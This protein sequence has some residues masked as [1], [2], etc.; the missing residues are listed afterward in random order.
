MKVFKKTRIRM[1]TPGMSSRR[2]GRNANS[3]RVFEKTRSRC[4]PQGTLRENTVRMQAPRTSSKKHGP[5]A[6]PGKSSRKH[7]QDANPRTVFE[8]Q[9]ANPR[10]VFEKTRSRCKPQ[11]RL[12]ENT[13]RMQ[14]DGLP[15]NRCTLL[16]R[17]YPCILP[18]FLPVF[19]AMQA[20]PPHLHP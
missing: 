13:V 15:P 2:H 9:D 1:L 3:R 20:Q 5:D 16:F 4:K 6:T 17:T 10:S 12:R 14:T 7:G 19:W 18:M 8:K 11:E